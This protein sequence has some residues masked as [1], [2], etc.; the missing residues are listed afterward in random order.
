MAKYFIEAYRTTTYEIEVEAV[1]EQEALESISE[2]IADDF[3]PHL[4]DN[5]WDFDVMEDE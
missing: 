3:E 4:V 2:W 5:K 1:D